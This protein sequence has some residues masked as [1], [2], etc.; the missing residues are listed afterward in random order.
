MTATIM[1]NHAPLE[2]FKTSI[3]NMEIRNLEPNHVTLLLFA[4]NNAILKKIQKQKLF[5]TAMTKIDETKAL[6]QSGLND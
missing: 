6:A 4:E 2:N 1:H 5:A 3:M